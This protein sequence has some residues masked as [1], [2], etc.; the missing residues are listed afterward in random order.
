[1]RKCDYCDYEYGEWCTHPKIE[2]E[3]R[4]SN[5]P[6]TSSF[7]DLWGYI[8]ETPDWCPIKEENNGKHEN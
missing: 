8:D 1:M 3:E 6:S 7:G 5:P 4:R 2:E